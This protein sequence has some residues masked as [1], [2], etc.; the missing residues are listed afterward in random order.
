MMKDIQTLAKTDKVG[1]NWSKENYRGGYTSYASLS[2]LHCRY[3]SFVAFEEA[4]QPFA[5]NFAKSQGWNLE[6][7][8]LKMTHLWVNIM[9]ENTYHTLHFH[10]HSDLS[11]AY[12]LQ[13]PPSSVPLKLEDPRMNFYMNAPV[14]EHSTLASKELYHLVQAKAGDFVLFESWL[15]HEVPPNQSKKP[16][17][18]ISFNYSLEMAD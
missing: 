15:K 12:Y 7:M 10:P 16:R 3:P 8:E 2:D 18:S 4:L 14:R 11:G 1:Q 13:T 9:P 17:I 6:D 5:N